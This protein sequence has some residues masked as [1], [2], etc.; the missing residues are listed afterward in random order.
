[1]D[2]IIL[3]LESRLDFAKASG[4]HDLTFSVK[5]MPEMIDILKSVRRRNEIQDQVNESLSQN[6]KSLS[7]DMKSV[8]QSLQRI[9]SR[10]I[11]NIFRFKTLKLFKKKAKFILNFISQNKNEKNHNNFSSLFVFFNQEKHNL[12]H[13]FTAENVYTCFFN[14]ENLIVIIEEIQSK[15]SNDFQLDQM[16]KSDLI[17]LISEVA[18]SLL[19]HA[20]DK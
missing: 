16:S 1:M 3:E 2:E 12:I 10:N 17:T 7:Q 11:L 13:Q 6:N 9:I 15:F 14:F 18:K 19:K 8:K 5:E 4:K 20:V